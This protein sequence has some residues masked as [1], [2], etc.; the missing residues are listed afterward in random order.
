MSDQT[1][2]T[3]RDVKRLSPEILGHYHDLVM[4][5]DFEGFD[6]LLEIYKV[7]EDQREELRRDFRLYAERILQ[8]RWRGQ[9]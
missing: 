8:R 9:K 2:H 7:P 5:N 3:R 1:T 4:A 6:M